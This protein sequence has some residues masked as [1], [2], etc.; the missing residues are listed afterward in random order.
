MSIAVTNLGV[1]TGTTPQAPDIRDLTD[2]STYTIPSWDPPDSG[3]VCLAIFSGENA[4]NIG[5]DSVT[6]NGDFWTQVDGKSYLDSGTPTRDIEF[7]VAYG[8]SLTTGATL[9]DFAGI[10]QVFCYVSIFQITGADEQVGQPQDCFISSTPGEGTGTGTGTIDLAPAVFAGNRALI[11]LAHN[12]NEA[13][14]VDASYTKID[15]MNGAGPTMGIVT[16]YDP[17]GYADPAFTWTTSANFGYLAFEIQEGPPRRPKGYSRLFGPAQLSTVATTLL[18]VHPSQRID[19]RNIDVN[20]PT[21]GTVTATFSIL[22]DESVSTRFVEVPI[23][24]GESINLRRFLGNQAL[25]VGDFIQGKASA[26]SSLVATI[27]G[28]VTDA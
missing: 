1:S 8:A 12:A 25:E 22:S 21:A 26:D 17:D 13:I 2:L 3:I 20:N 16:A 28:Y 24:A 10:T 19:V 11:L 15:D 5:I 7:F 6:G 4:G 14:T 23:P 27:N 9:I 18:T